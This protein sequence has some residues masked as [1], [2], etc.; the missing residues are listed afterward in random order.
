MA[1]LARY[2]AYIPATVCEGALQKRCLLSRSLQELVALGKC[3]ILIQLSDCM[4]ISYLSRD[5]AF[6][7]LLLRNHSPPADEVLVLVIFVIS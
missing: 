7:S 4:C 3:D 6:P 1:G 2:G 5:A